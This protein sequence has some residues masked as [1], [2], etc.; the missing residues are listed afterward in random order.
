MIS[1]RRA[2]PEY[3]ETLTQIALDAKRH[4]GYPD[5]WMQIWTP[6]LT[7]SPEYFDVN[8]SWMAEVDDRPVAFYTLLDNDGIAWLENLWV[9]PQYI[10]EGIGRRL[11][12]HAANT[13]RERGFNLFQLEADPNAAGFYEKMGMHRIGERQ[14]EVDGQPRTLPLMEMKL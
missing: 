3:A 4:W 12:V 2:K 1:I 6:Q 14:Y 10:G 11:F 5:R 13:A 9:S 8:E 7:F